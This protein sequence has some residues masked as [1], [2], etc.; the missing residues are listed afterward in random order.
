MTFPG[1]IAYFQ[2]ELRFDPQQGLGVAAD[3]ITGWCTC[4]FARHGCRKVPAPG[5]LK[6]LAPEVVCVLWSSWCGLSCGGKRPARPLT[7]AA[8][9]IMPDRNGEFIRGGEGEEWSNMPP[10]N[11]GTGT[12]MRSCEERMPTMARDGRQNA[13]AGV[14]LPAARSASIARPTTYGGTKRRKR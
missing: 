7:A 10:S 1:G 2:P 14:P 3:V 4:R 13:L 12:E 6:R 9:K 8:L 11:R 5:R